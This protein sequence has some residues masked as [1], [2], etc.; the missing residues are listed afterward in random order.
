LDV[1]ADM[2]SSMRLSGG[3][4]LD[5]EFRAPW[6]VISHIGPDDCA[7]FFPV[8]AHVIGYHFVRSGRLG[9]QVG[10][11]P[12]IEVTAGEIVMLPRNEPHYLHGSTPSTPVDARSLLDAPGED[13]LFHLSWGGEGEQ[14]TV[15]CGYLGSV[16][17]DNMLFQHLPSIMKIDA[18][19]ALHGDWMV[20]SLDFA[21][22]GLGIT[23]PE[24]VG[25]LAEGLFAEAV[26]RY[27]EAMPAGDSGWLAGLRDPAVA[28]ALSLIHTRF[29]DAW[30]LDELA[31]EAGVSKTILADRF[32]ALLGEPP[33][34]YC[35]RWRMRRAGDLLRDNRQNACSVAYAVG[36]N[37][38]AAFN[39]AFKREYGVPPATWQRAALS[40]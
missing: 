20:K 18:A 6:S 21:T 12:V 10:E 37:S 3:E 39:R 33:M 1:L 27:F 4:F 13:G 5:G 38:E 19:D 35:A 36:F 14:T 31:R 34:Q 32:R 30:T 23:S 7:R 2:L 25:K 11:G 24:M 9:C 8:P 29:A 26:R 16:T 28:R 15:F 17:P 40:Q 22:R